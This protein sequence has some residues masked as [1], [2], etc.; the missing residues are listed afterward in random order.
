M[1]V[2]LTIIAA[3]LLSG[4]AGAPLRLFTGGGPNVAANTQAGTFNAQGVGTTKIASHKVEA[5]VVEAVTQD[6]SENRV[7]AEQVE[8]I[9]VKE[10][11]PVWMWG[12]LFVAIFLPTP[13]D[14][15]REFGRGLALLWRVFRGMPAFRKAG[16]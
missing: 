11:V 4:C 10:G 8:T 5:E 14:V 16:R 15:L 2:R 13:T 6:S 1:V 3:L 9:I 7:Q 12:L